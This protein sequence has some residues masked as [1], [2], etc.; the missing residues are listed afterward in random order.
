MGKMIIK[1]VLP[2]VVVL[3]L[4]VLAADA[5]VLYGSGLLIF[6]PALRN[7]ASCIITAWIIAVCE[8]KA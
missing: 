5:A 3:A 7:L 2:S 4:I 6:S 1:R 8:R